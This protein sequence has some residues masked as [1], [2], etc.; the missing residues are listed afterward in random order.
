MTPG[1]NDRG[2]WLALRVLYLGMLMKERDVRRL[3]VEELEL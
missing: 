2:R 3:R 1:A